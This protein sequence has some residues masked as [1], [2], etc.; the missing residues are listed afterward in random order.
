LAPSEIRAE[1]FP[2]NPARSLTPAKKIEAIIEMREILT[3]L[4]VW[5]SLT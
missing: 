1:D 4:F 2:T 5:L 3:P